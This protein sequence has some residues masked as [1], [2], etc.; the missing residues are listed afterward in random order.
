MNH[1]ST[2]ILTTSPYYDQYYRPI[3]L[4]VC[5][6]NIMQMVHFISCTLPIN[7]ISMLFHIFYVI[8]SSVFPVCDFKYL[9]EPKHNTYIPTHSGDKPSNMSACF[10]LIP[11]VCEIIIIFTTPY[12]KTLSVFTE[13][14]FNYTQKPKQY[15][16]IITHKGEKPSSFTLC[17]IFILLAFK[18]IIMQMVQF[19]SYISY[20]N[21]ISSL[22]TIFSV[23]TPFVSTEC[24]FKYTNEL[25]QQP[26]MLIHSEEKPFSC[27]VCDYNSII[28]IIYILI[29]TG[30]IST[31]TKKCNHDNATIII[32]I[33]LF[34]KKNYIYNG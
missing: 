25:I 29:H 8:Y 27:T 31:Y 13:C 2:A 16:Y 14:D 20:T 23:K 11:L 3:I 6:I 9:Q 22:F 28:Q 24:D 34:N 17:F 4:L 12:V 33:L 32:I 1:K 15:I 19:I 30:E 5:K 7:R 26:H 10:R 21:R 18:V